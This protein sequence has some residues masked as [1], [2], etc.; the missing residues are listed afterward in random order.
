MILEGLS[1][2]RL[3]RSSADHSDASSLESWRSRIGVAIA[4][5]EP[6]WSLFYGGD[7][8]PPLEA[9]S[10]V[11]ETAA[12]FTIALGALYDRTVKLAADNVVVA[13]A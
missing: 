7:P 11:L 10:F 13:F 9:V 1:V 6:H 8:A 2:S 5:V 12:T 3:A 4:R